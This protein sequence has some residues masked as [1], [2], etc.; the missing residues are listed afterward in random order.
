[1]NG[2]DTLILLFCR[3]K[4]REAAIVG[5]ARKSQKARLLV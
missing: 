3:E 1:M 2:H 5:T 4:P